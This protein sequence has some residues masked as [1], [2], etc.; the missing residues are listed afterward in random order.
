MLDV[1]STLSSVDGVCDI[2]VHRPA[3][4]PRGWLLIE[5]P[6][7]ATRKSDYDLLAGRL[8]SALPAQL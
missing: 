2:E 3:E 6:H 5:V 8:K 4:P 1:A 7:G